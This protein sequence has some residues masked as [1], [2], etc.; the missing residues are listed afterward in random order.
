MERDRIKQLRLQAARTDHSSPFNPSKENNRKVRL[1]PSKQLVTLYPTTAS[2][3]LIN[4]PS[5][6]HSSHPSITNPN[7]PTT[8]PTRTQHANPSKHHGTREGY[9]LA[10]PDSRRIPH[11][12]HD[13]KYASPPPPFSHPLSKTSNPQTQIKQ[14]SHPSSSALPNP[15]SSTLTS[16]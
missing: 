2:I 3:R 9:L 14:N 6:H 5:T 1:P 8:P 12:L 16:F 15:L 13:R 10:H 11:T 7:P 4:H